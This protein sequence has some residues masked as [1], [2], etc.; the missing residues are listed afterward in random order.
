MTATWF[1]N[2]MPA[3]SFPIKNLRCYADKDTLSKKFEIEGRFC[4]ATSLW[5]AFG[6]SQKVTMTARSQGFKMV[7][8]LQGISAMIANGGFE[9]GLQF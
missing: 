8:S 7:G 5:L 1:C 2:N 3:A 9:R 4:G 6:M